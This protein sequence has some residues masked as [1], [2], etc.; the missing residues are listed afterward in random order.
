M[1]KFLLLKHYGLSPEGEPGHAPIFGWTP[2]EIDAHMAYQRQLIAELRESGEY[3]DVQALSNDSVLVR[4]GGEG[5][6]PV[7]TDGPYAESKELVAGWYL[8]DVESKE[9]AYEI[10]ARVSAAP[11]AG[12]KPGDELLEVRPILSM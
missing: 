6:P 1:A 2:E 8:I 4:T 12:G 3:V 11:G 9:R 7:V 5:A 10:A